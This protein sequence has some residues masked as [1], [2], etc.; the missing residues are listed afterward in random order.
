MRPAEKHWCEKSRGGGEQKEQLTFF[1]FGAGILI[2][3]EEE[4]RLILEQRRERLGSP[5]GEVLT[6]YS[7]GVAVESKWSSP[8]TRA[9]RSVCVMPLVILFGHQCE[10]V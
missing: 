3:T 1:S 9:P 5:P 6:F 7:P 10:A 2:L 8:C 4:K